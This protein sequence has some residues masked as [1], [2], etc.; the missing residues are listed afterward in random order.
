MK[1]EA[2]RDLVLKKVCPEPNTGCWLW[3]GELVGK[4]QYGRCEVG[5]RRLLAHRLSWEVFNGPIPE[6]VLVLHECDTPTCCNP[7]HL[8][9][10]SH[11]D[12]IDDRVSKGRSCRGERSPS[13]RITSEQAAQIRCSGDSLRALAAQFGIS[14]KT[15]F[16]IKHGLKWKEA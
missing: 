14:A 12:N 13:A 5:G 7:D 16:D 15:V 11:Q 3:L 2:T 6:G 10:G 1:N 9:L 4:L 8:F